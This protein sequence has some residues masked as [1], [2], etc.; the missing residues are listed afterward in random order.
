M[1]FFYKKKSRKK[2]SPFLVS[3]EKKISN[4]PLRLSKIL[5]TP[6]RCPFPKNLRS[7]PPKKSSA[8]PCGKHNEC[9]LNEVQLYTEWDDNH[10]C[11]STKSVNEL[12]GNP[13]WWLLSLTKLS[14]ELKDHGQHGLI[15]QIYFD[16][17]FLETNNHIPANFFWVK[18]VRFSPCH[19]CLIRNCPSVFRGFPII[20][21]NLLNFT[22]NSRKCSD[23]LWALKKTWQL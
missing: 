9:S 4:P 1:V 20:F 2:K 12:R 22:E 15:K 14:C 7:P 11:M 21:R 3:G 17:C 18:C 6:H 8:P 16:K 23:D 10:V 13:T 5:V 19:N